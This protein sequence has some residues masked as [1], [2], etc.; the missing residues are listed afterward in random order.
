MR[1]IYSILKQIHTQRAT[2]DMKKGNISLFDPNVERPELLLKMFHD[3]RRGCEWVLANTTEGNDVS[4]LRE[5]AFAP[6]SVS[7][8]IPNNLIARIVGKIITCRKSG[9][10]PNPD[11]LVLRED[12]FEFGKNL[13]TLTVKY[14]SENILIRFEPTTGERWV[15]KESKPKIILLIKK[16]DSLIISVR[17]H[18]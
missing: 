6:L 15:L 16:V 1:Y 4:R 5:E 11:Y 17:F 8:G 3:F 12:M 18:D 13:N 7:M 14:G 9:K 10:E 2:R